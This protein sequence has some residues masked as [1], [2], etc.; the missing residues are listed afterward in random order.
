MEPSGSQYAYYLY[1]C[2]ASA[3]ED[4]G[5]KESTAS[6]VITNRLITIYYSPRVRQPRKL[7]TGVDLGRRIYLELSE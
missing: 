2:L 4:D 5:G 1:V 7:W 3:A 6:S